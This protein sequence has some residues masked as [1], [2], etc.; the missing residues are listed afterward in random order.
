MKKASLALSL[1]LTLWLSANCLGQSAAEAQHFRGS[2]LEVTYYK[3]SPFAFVPIGNNPW[4]GSFQRLPDWKP[5]PG[6]TPIEAVELATRADEGAIKI[7]VTVFRG[8][9]FDIKD[10][11]AE[12]ELNGKTLILED[13]AKV[14]IVPFEVR[15]VAAPPTVSALPMLENKTRSLVVSVEPTTATLPSFKVRI[16]NSSAKP[17]LSVAYRTILNSRNAGSAAP[18]NRNGGALIEPGSTYETVVRYPVK[19]IT[20][21]TGELPETR[22]GLT[23]EIQ[24]VVFAD[25]S[26]EGEPLQAALFRA[27]K[28]GE[29][30]Q[31]T[32]IVEL[33]RSPSAASL[34]TLSPL[35]E[36]LRSEIDLEDM[37]PLA[38]EFPELSKP[39]IEDIR[40]IAE[41][42]AHNFQQEFRSRFGK[43]TTITP[44]QLA[45]AV[46]TTI[47][48]C[49]ARIDSLP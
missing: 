3:G 19:L 15:L 46:K 27:G 4:F 11:I 7:R 31:V 8:K 44:A 29:K 43:G 20:I 10:F 45:D 6:E 30:I 21:S 18:R 24:A 2:V 32:R 5:K 9:Y 1:L 16:L 48:K 35:A 36:T 33:L 38:V 39:Q 40:S 23:L 26:W 12:Y 13:L 22:S 37:G 34:E 14:G 47:A 42:S 25:G 41:M 28:L 17:V 49:Q